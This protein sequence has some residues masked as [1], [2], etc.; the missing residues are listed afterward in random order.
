MVDEFQATVSQKRV[1]RVNR[2]IRVKMMAAKATTD[3][4]QLFS[5]YQDVRHTGGDMATMDYY[6]YQALIEETPVDSLLVEF[7]NDEGV[8]IAGCLVDRMSDGL[9]AVYSFFDPE[10]N[11]R[12]LGTY[13]ILWLMER[14]RELDLSYV[15]LGYWISESQKMAYKEKFQPLELY[16]SN[17]WRR[18]TSADRQA[19]AE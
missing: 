6:D 17:G 10:L 19:A 15:Y 18:F 16:T 14:A 2:D 9:S 1:M 4:F 5:R 3:Q 7:R 8:L 12:S 13:M 11:R